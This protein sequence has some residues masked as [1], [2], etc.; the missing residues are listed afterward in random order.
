MTNV[1]PSFINLRAN[2]VGDLEPQQGVF[3]LQGRNMGSV[4]AEIRTVFS[5]ATDITLLQ[6]SPSSAAVLATVTNADFPLIFR[7]ASNI[8]QATHPVFSPAVV[9][10]W[11]QDIPQVMDTEPKLVTLKRTTDGNAASTNIDIVMIGSDLTRIDTN[12]ATISGLI[13][14]M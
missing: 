5:N 2:A 1:I 8:P 9:V 13:F 14:V 4:S 3:V 6:R 11:P 12:G 7:L 10:R